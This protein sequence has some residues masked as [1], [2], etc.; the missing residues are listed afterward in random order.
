MQGKKSFSANTCSSVNHN[1]IFRVVAKAANS[2]LV[3]KVKDRFG[4]VYQETMER[5][6]K[7]YDGSN[8]ANT[9][10]LD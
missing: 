9:W 1:H 10:T 8:I 7:F 4:N 5:P 3:I 2:K 6:K